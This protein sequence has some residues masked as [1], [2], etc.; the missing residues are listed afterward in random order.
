MDITNFIGWFIDVFLN[1]F[2]FI[3]NTLDS[4]TF[5]NISLLQYMIAILVLF[6]I[7]TLLFTLVT[8]QRVYENGRDIINERKEKEKND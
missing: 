4:I 8:T 7:L 2:K 1:I 3:Y 5:Y 6:P